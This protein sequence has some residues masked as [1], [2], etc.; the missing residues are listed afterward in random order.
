VILEK[1][2]DSIMISYN[3]RFIPDIDKIPNGNRREHCSAHRSKISAIGR[4]KGQQVR[5]ERY[6]PDGVTFQDFALYTIIAVHDKESDVVFVGF[7]SPGDLDKRLGLPN[8]EPFTGKINSQ[9]T[10]D[11]DF[12]EHLTDNGRHKGLIVIAPHAVISRNTPMSKRSAY[13][14]SLR[15]NV[16][17]YGFARVLK[18]VVALLTDGISHRRT[19]ARSH[20]RS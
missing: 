16:S 14:N 1:Q 5:I 15:Q 9:V 2:R 10:D 6:A 17:P 3:A 13:A 11:R 12:V 18:K 7:D 8:I 19:S 4:N 20:S